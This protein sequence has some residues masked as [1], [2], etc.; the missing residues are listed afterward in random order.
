VDAT[1][2]SGI[3]TDEDDRAVYRFRETVNRSRTAALKGNAVMNRVWGP[4]R[5][6]LMALFVCG[7]VSAC[8]TAA[9]S[10]EPYLPRPLSS[11]AAA[12]PEEP[13]DVKFANFVRD[14]RETALAAGIRPETYDRAMAG[15]RRDPRVE[16]ANLQQPEFVKPVWEYLDSAVS[17]KRV[18]RG[19]ALAG[20]NADMLDRVERRFGV[21]RDILVAIWGIESNYGDAMGRLSLFQSLATLAY[22]G[23]RAEYGRRELIAA[24]K[25]MEREDLD[26]R[27]MT[28]SW[29][30]AFGQ[31]QF[32]PST[33]LTDAVSADGSGR[34]DLWHSPA[35]ALAS[36]ANLLANAGWKAGERWGFEVTLPADFDDADADIDTLRPLATWKRAGVRRAD[37][38]VFPGGDRQGAIILPAG[39]RGPAFM[40]FDNFRTVLKYNNAQSYALA[41][42]TLADRIAGGAPVL[43]PWPREEIPL[44]RDERIAFQIDLRKLGYDPGAIDGV[45]GHQVRAQLRAWQ[46][47]HG[48]PADGFA[49]EDLLARMEREIVAHG[50]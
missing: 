30:G 12:R 11:D 36:T 13:A 5:H 39:A 44:T 31:T 4:V 24:M 20:T 10:H 23:P 40:V 43:A 32:V 18:A 35:D 3:A 38:G 33:F 45:F 49:T 2:P 48:L 28:S 6:V 27:I 1:F 29:A 50:G 16:E 34:I 21:S 25:M 17:D 7:P 19:Q 14:F 46:K 9:P 26:P 47:A 37:G 41:V 15:L 42:C 22:D 8:A